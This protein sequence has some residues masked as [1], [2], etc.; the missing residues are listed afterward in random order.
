M[1]GLKVI[2]LSHST[3]PAILARRLWV[4]E[5]LRVLVYNLGGS[6]FD[7]SLVDHDIYDGVLELVASKG[8]THFG[9]Q[10]FDMRVVDYFVNLIKSKYKRDISKDMKALGKLRIECEKAKVLLSSSER[11]MIKI[12]S[13]DDEIMLFEEPL[14]RETFEEL[15]MDLFNKTI[16]LVR[17]VINEGDV[18][19]KRHLDEIVLVGGN[20]RIPRIQHMLKEEFGREPMKD[21]NPDEAMAFAATHM[22]G[23]Y[24]G[25][26]EDGKRKLYIPSSTN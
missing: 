23:L 5:N 26:L 6:A 18:I 17:S 25:K 3:L 14:T 13:L 16:E 9:G 4:Q 24:S 10:T 21:V 8:D 15:N 1:I 11:V 12:E 19:K 7:A 22:A 20:A 2:P